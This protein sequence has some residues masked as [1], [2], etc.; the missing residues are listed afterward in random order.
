MDD[1]L[2]AGY[3]A[4][5]LDLDRAADRAEL[6]R[7]RA[8]P[9]VQFLDQR[10][11]QLSG[12]RGLRPPPGPDLLEER[13]KWAYYPWRRAVVGVLGP[14]GFRALR[15]DRNR[16]NITTREQTRLGEL[17]IGVA[18]LSVGHVIA[19]TLAAQGLAGRLWLADFDH[20]ELSNLNR[21]PATVF[22]LGVNKAHVAARRIAEL[23]PYLPVD[24]FDAGLTADTV[25]AFLDGLDIVVEECDSLDM[26]ALLRIGARARRIP[27]LMATSDRGIVDVERFDQEPARPILH[28]LLGDLD[29]ALL[30]GMSSRDKIPHMLRHLEAE[31]LSPRAAASLIEIDRSLS[32]WP[33]LA[34]DV[35]LGAS[36]LAEAVRRVGLGEELKS[37]R[38]R[39]D[40]GGALDQLDEPDMAKPGSAAAEYPPPPTATDPIVTAAMRAPSGGNS[41][42]WHIVAEPTQITISIAPQHTSTMDSGFRGS[43]VALGAALFNVRI[44]AAAHRMLGPVSLSEDANGSPL[45]ATM[46]FDGGEDSALAELYEPMLARATNRHH[47]TSR[48]LRGETIESLTAAAD[49]EG[50]R[51]HLITDKDQLTSA[52]A[53]L[54]AADRIRYLTPQLH[55]EMISELR[56]PGDP[57][58]DTGID[59]H[60]LELDAGDLALLGVLRRPEVMARLAEWDAGDALGD[61]M[62]DRVLTSSALAVVTVTGRGLRDYARGGSAVE[63]VWIKA[64]REGL[65]V[66]PLSPVFLHAQTTS[67]LRAMSP[68][69][70]GELRQQQS[71][72]VRLAATRP[73]ESIVLILRFTAAPPASVASR[74]SASRVE[75]PRNRLSGTGP[76]GSDR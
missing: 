50:A 22:D 63:A 61:D 58:P 54:A 31:Q 36:A 35:V 10:D 76:P 4:R 62:R 67:D 6:E 25:D 9:R 33:Q 8:D 23:D 53:I 26:K 60:T 7:L 73:D 56:W 34:S 75:S 13:P 44:A 68:A 1:Q 51:M 5:I 30:P 18:G 72:F 41:Q 15:L 2:V 65:S 14:R 21:V 64:Q 16:N 28:G 45:R 12:L 71:D 48:P 69:F 55:R 66:Q 32:T 46:R 40:V 70:A 43:A 3:R 59:V 42:P 57:D 19:H 74:R 20:L 52:A 29:I 11:A 49:R 24:V 37:G 17:S 39:I 38:C 47:G 27:V